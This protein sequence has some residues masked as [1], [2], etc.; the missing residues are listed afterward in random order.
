M[1]IEMLLHEINAK[2]RVIKKDPKGLV[3][4]LPYETIEKIV[5]LLDFKD[6]M[7]LRTAS[8]RTKEMV[9]YQQFTVFKRYQKGDP[10]LLRTVVHFVENGFSPPVL[11]AIIDIQES[12]IRLMTPGL[13]PV[14]L[15]D[16]LSKSYNVFFK[17]AM[18]HFNYAT[19]KLLSTVTI[20]EMLLMST[21]QQFSI[22]SETPNVLELNLLT[23]Y[24]HDKVQFIRK[25]NGDIV[26][27]ISELAVIDLARFGQMPQQISLLIKSS[28]KFIQAFK[29]CLSNGKFHIDSPDY[30]EASF[31]FPA[32][33]V[34]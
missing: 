32:G 21:N 10:E 29:N 6:K 31:F 13:I 34:Q 2:S 30:V 9:D 33:E 22:V 8:K 17:Q 20:I 15:C 5:G 12:L 18:R 24:K 23:L 26:K 4:A 14:H 19:F 3:Q 27:F 28:P 25:C 1:K 11:H 16:R 7:N